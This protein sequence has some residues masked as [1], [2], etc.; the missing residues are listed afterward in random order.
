MTNLNSDLSELKKDTVGAGINIFTQATSS[1]GY[2]VPESG[3]I[4]IINGGSTS[5]ALSIYFDSH[6]V[7]AIA[8]SNIWSSERLSLF[9]RKGVVIKAVSTMPTVSLYLYPYS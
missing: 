4:T 3:Y 6:E 2:V 7:I 9:V 5:G 1:D 8:G